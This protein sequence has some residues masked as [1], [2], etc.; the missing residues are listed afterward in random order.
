M[1][2]VVFGI[3]SLGAILLVSSCSFPHWFVSHR[4]VTV[5]AAAGNAPEI[6]Q[7]RE[8]MVRKSSFSIEQYFRSKTLN[9][10]EKSFSVSYQGKLIQPKVYASFPNEKYSRRLMELTTIPPMTLMQ[11]FFKVKRKQGDTIRIVEHDVPQIN[12][13]IV[14]NVEI[15][16]MDEK[17]DDIDRYNFS[18]L[19]QLSNGFMIDPTKRN[20]LYYDLKFEDGVCVRD[21]VVDFGHIV[22]N[23]LQGNMEENMNLIMEKNEVP[24]K[25]LNFLYHA[26]FYNISISNDCDLSYL[27]NKERTPNEKLKIRVKFYENVKQPYN[28]DY[29]FAIIE[30]IVPNQ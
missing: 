18:Q 11:V 3:F 22:G 25:T 26:N 21:F 8:T 16:E 6:V 23:I 9:V 20:G 15:P 30:S 5:E 13:S 19:Y 12:D 10:S 17:E 27:K 7:V 29:P 2:K 28:T 24:Q 1:K 14:I 4:H